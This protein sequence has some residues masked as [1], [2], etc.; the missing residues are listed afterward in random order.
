MKRTLTFNEGIISGDIV[1]DIIEIIPESEP[2]FTQRKTYDEY[3][4]NSLKVTVDLETIEKLN[5]ACYG[6]E[7]TPEYIK[8]S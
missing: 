7:I 1:R 2:M 3:Y 4:T 8:I 6:V 5:E